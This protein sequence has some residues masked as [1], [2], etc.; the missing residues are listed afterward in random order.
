[1]TSHLPVPSR[2]LRG[3]FLVSV[4]VVGL[5]WTEEQ[6]ASLRAL[7]RELGERY[8]FWELVVVAPITEVVAPALLK[9][10][11]G[12][13]N[14]RVL[15]VD[16]VDNFYRL[17][18][19]AASEAIGDV[20]LL[21]S[22]DELPL[23]DL[24]ALADKVYETNEVVVMARERQGLLVETF[25]GALGYLIGYRIDPR[26]TLTAGFPRT[27]LSLVLAR[28][29]ADLL[30]RFE[31]RTGANQ[32]HREPMPDR[33]RVPRALRSMARRFRLLADLLA[34]AAPRV[35]RSVAALSFAVAI[36]AAVYG[37]YAIAVWVLKENVAPGW[38]TTSMLQVVIVGFLGITVSAISIGIVKLLDRIEG[39]LRYTIVDE[40]NNV[41]FFSDV[42]GLN[43]ETHR[44]GAGK[45]N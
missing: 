41:D 29:D 33:A 2:P 44:D 1:M 12:I 36:F 39:I 19:A 14:I 42:K 45:G 26:D 37:V 32:F 25:L 40:L 6:I 30:L 34:S 28:P 10:L 16:E 5:A 22:G 43:V 15:R 11:M 4:A 23:M 18:L 9:D 17:R 35:L 27:W 21:T 7:A 38:L 3:D 31:R 24:P 20:V 13:A 8:Q